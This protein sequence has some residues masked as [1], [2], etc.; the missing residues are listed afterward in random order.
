MIDYCQKFEHCLKNNDDM[1]PEDSV[2]CHECGA[3]RSCISAVLNNKVVK[4]VGFGMVKR[5]LRN[6]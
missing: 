4:C 5:H 6:Q 2:M 1:I 3:L